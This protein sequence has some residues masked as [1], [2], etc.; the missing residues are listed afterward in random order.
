MK[1]TLITL[2]ILL[3][4]ISSCSLVVY[5]LSLLSKDAIAYILSSLGFI[6]MFIGIRGIV[7]SELKYRE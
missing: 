3:G 7:A 1:A 2:V 6:V 5:G 4:L